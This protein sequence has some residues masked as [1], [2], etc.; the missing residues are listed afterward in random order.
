MNNNCHQIKQA[1]DKLEKLVYDFNNG[2]EKK[3]DV[4]GMLKLRDKINAEID[5][6]YDELLDKFPE[7]NVIEATTPEGNEV[8]FEISEQLKYWKKFYQDRGIDWIKLPERILLKKEQRQEIIRLI[9]KVG[10]D[11]M[12]IIPENLADT[13]ERY[14]KLHEKTTEG[15]KESYQSDNFKKDGGFAGIKNKS[16]GL[17]IIMVK[18]VQNL[19]DDDF[20]SQTKG[21][22]VKDLEAKEG[23]FE[24]YRVRGIDLAVY[25]IWQREY[26]ERTGKDLDKTGWTWLPEAKSPSSSSILTAHWNPDDECLDFDPDPFDEPGDN[27]G[28]RLAGTI[29]L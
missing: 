13:G 3:E 26:Y 1:L 27:L 7:L 10:M 22:S 21:K 20:Y 17:R 24:K 8:R 11:K 18:D 5:K 23:I 12:L 2:M 6:M 9:E 28:C 4:D 14:E 15:Y 29:E 16:N 25:L 19:E